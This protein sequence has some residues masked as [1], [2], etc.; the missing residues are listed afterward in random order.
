MPLYIVMAITDDLWSPAVFVAACIVFELSVI[1]GL[2]RPQMKPLERVGWAATV[3]RDHR[4]A[5]ARVLLPGRKPDALGMQPED[6]LVPG[7][8]VEHR[9]VDARGLR[10]H[11][12]LAGPEGGD[13]VVLVHGWPQ[14]WW[15]W[16]GVL[17]ALVD[18]GYRCICVDLRGHGWTDAPPDGYEKEQFASDVLAALDELGVDRFKLIGH[19]WGGFASFLIALREPAAGGEAARALDRPSVDQAEGGLGPAAQGARQRVVPVRALNAR[20]RAPR[21]YGGCRSSTRSSRWAPAAAWIAETREKYASRFKEPDRARGTSALYRT[22]LLREL[23]PI[24]K[25][26]YSDQRL[27]VPTVLMFGDSDRVIT[28]RRLAGF[29]EHADDMR[30]EN[31]ADTSHFLPDE[32]PARVAEQALA[33]FSR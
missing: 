4:P 7:V 3:G 29:E 6:L 14:H 26:R 27:T 24:L 15:I 20:G 18:A 25:G 23:Q 8:E 13:P 5:R 1:F 22:F 2:A 10:T 30:L 31:V 16:R 9:Y 12:A 19:D 11:V 33:L 17:P 21:S 32:Q 28:E